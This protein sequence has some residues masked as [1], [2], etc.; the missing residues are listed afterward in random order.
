MAQTV[1]GRRLCTTW[2]CGSPTCKASSVTLQSKRV[3][4]A[5][6]CRGAVTPTK[7]D[8]GPLLDNPRAAIGL[9]AFDDG[10]VGRLTGLVDAAQQGS[11]DL[12]S[13]LGQIVGAA[14]DGLAAYAPG[15]FGDGDDPAKVLC[16]RSLVEVVGAVGLIGDLLAVTVPGRPPIQDD[17]KCKGRPLTCQP[18]PRWRCIQLPKGG[19]LSIGPAIGK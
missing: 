12:G 11:Q 3:P 16:V 13:A 9:A 19:C 8:L 6:P 7:L 14:V 4:A 10:A 18:E 2:P 17:R 5:G 15:A 1:A